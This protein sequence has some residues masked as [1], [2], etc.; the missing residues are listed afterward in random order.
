MKLYLTLGRAYRRATGTGIF[1]FDGHSDG[2]LIT[3]LTSARFGLK[4]SQGGGGSRP[5]MEIMNSRKCISR[6]LQQIAYRTPAD[7]P[8]VK[9]LWTSLMD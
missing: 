2:G 7:R 8:M 1:D 5:Y 4:V 3:G 9:G 6:V